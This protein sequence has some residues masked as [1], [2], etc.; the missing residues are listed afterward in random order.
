MC[1]P[2]HLYIWD[3]PLNYI[4][5][6]A[7]MQIESLLRENGSTAIF[8]EHDQRFCEQAATREFSLD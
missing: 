1:E 3:E 8:V 7:R 5:V 6:I 2:A 4:D